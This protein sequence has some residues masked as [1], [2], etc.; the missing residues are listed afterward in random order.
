MAAHHRSPQSASPVAGN[1]NL[2]EREISKILMRSSHRSSHIAWI[3]HGGSGAFVFII[4][5]WPH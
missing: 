3:G 2:G 1:E 5:P 4:R